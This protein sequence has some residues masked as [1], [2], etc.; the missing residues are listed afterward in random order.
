MAPHLIEELDEKFLKP[1]HNP[2]LR[3]LYKRKLNP[4]GS[5]SL[6][7][8]PGIVIKLFKRLV[9][10]ILRRILGNEAMKDRDV[11]GRYY[12]AALIVVK[13]RRVNHVQNWCRMG[14]SID[15][16]EKSFPDNNSVTTT[17]STPPHPKTQKK[18]QSS[19]LLI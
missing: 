15:L 9:L 16:P 18:G 8:R 12:Q 7:Q 10:P 5:R 1:L 19:G 17:H 11:V 2:L 3:R 6:K 4:D 14:H 13:K